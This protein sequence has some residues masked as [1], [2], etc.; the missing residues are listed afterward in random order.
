MR[1]LT[2]DGPHLNTLGHSFTYNNSL[3]SNLKAKNN[4]PKNKEEIDE[5]R[6]LKM[7]WGRE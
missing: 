5:F 1:S 6:S 4:P 7:T 2:F 3:L